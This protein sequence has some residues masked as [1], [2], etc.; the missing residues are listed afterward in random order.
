M[1]NNFVGHE[2]PRVT[3]ERREAGR[4]QRQQRKNRIG[5]TGL[6]ANLGIISASIAYE[7]THRESN[8]Q[9][10]SSM[11]KEVPFTNDSALGGTIIGLLGMIY[12]I[13][14]FGST[15]RRGYPG[16][17]YVNLPDSHPLCPYK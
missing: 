11:A 15:E 13:T 3:H 16:D 9:N 10:E 12:S 14:R 1:A 5:W 8:Q 6:V 7:V 4:I 17:M 2:E